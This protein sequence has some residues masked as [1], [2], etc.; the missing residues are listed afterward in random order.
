MDILE[1]FKI[2]FTSAEQQKIIEESYE[3]HR[4]GLEFAGLLMLL[5]LVP[6]VSFGL[7]LIFG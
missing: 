5:G 3:D 2:D 7:F 1:K 4:A 6:I